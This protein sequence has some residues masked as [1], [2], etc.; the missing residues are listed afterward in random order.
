VASKEKKESIFGSPLLL[1]KK[2]N[3]KR[4]KGE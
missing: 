4:E 1:L 3:S 2:G